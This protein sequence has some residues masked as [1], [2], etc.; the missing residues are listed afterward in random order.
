MKVV[1][2]CDHGGFE[3]KEK[4]VSRLENQGFEVEDVGTHSADSVD[5]PIYAAKVARAVSQGQAQR[6]VLICGSGIGMSIAANRFRTVR[7]VHACNPYEARMSR[8][9][10]ASNVLCLGGRFVGQDMAFEI[11]DTWLRED[12]EGGGR[13]QRRIDQIDRLACDTGRED[14]LPQE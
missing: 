3:L 11:L 7:A 5:Y 9:H 8:R 6:G 12:F 4:I 2:G 10:N 14:P 1:V 13:H